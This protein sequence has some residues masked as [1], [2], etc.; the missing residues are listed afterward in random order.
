MKNTWAIIPVL[1]IFAAGCQ[2]DLFAGKVEGVAGTVVAANGRTPL[3]GAAVTL[4]D[5][6]PRGYSGTATT[7]S[8]GGFSFPAAPDGVYK[9]NVNSPNGLFAGTF[10]GEVVNGHFPDGVK[11]RMG[12]SQVGTFLNIPGRY[13]DMGVVLGDLGYPYATMDASRLTEDPNPI[14]G[15]DLV[16][17]NSGADAHAA[18]DPQVIANLRSFVDAGG[19]LLA[20]DAAWP[21][22]AAAWP[23]EIDW[24]SD[25][26]IGKGGQ[27]PDTVITNAGLEAAAWTGAWEI[28]YDQ[29]KW[30]LPAAATEM[31]F[32]RGDVQTYEGNRNNAP[33]LVGFA[34]GN[35]Y[36]AFATF[37]W[38]TQYDQSRLPVRAFNY[39]VANE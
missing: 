37:N 4:E 35:G 1:T 14:E 15:Y 17:L 32:V 36:V 11:M 21:F 25:P 8:H 29:P 12:A 39:L 19:R 34:F 6:K 38:R 31:T 20:S 30:A 18:A 7:D 3:Y 27:D 26:E 24:G 5:V 23:G 9:I 13:D 2:T 28:F 22:L 33:L 16:L 10:K